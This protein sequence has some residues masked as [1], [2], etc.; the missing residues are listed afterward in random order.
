[1]GYINGSENRVFTDSTFL[2]SHFEQSTLENTNITMYQQ[3]SNSDA[4]NRNVR[5]E[6]IPIPNCWS[7]PETMPNIPTEI[8]PP[9]VLNIAPASY[10]A[11]TAPTVN[12][13]LS[14]QGINIGIT[15]ELDAKLEDEADELL[16]MSDL[17]AE[18]LEAGGVQTHQ[19]MCTQFMNDGLCRFGNQCTFRHIT[20]SAKV[21]NQYLT[22]DNISIRNEFSTNVS[23]P[24]INSNSKRLT[25]NF[26]NTKEGCQMGKYCAYK[27]LQ[28][29]FSSM[30][31]NI[32]HTHHSLRIHEQQTSNINHPRSSSDNF[33]KQLIS[34]LNVLQKR[35]EIQTKHDCILFFLP[36]DIIFYGQQKYNINTL[37]RIA[38]FNKP[39]NIYST[40]NGN[41]DNFYLCVQC[42]Y[43][44]NIYFITLGSSNQQIENPSLQLFFRTSL[45][46]RW[47]EKYCIILWIKWDELPV[48]DSLVTFDSL[49]Y[50]PLIVYNRKLGV[51]S[52][53]K[54]R[55]V[56]STS[57]DIE[58]NVW[59]FVCVLGEEN[60]SS[61][62]VGTAFNDSHKSS[63]SFTTPKYVGS[64]E[65]SICGQDTIRI[66]DCG[67]GPG[68]MACLK[69]YNYHLT[70]E[71]MTHMYWQ[72]KCEMADQWTIANIQQIKYLLFSEYFPLPSVINLIV[73]YVCR[74]EY[75]AIDLDFI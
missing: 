70:V 23:T 61:F 48:F 27:H 52:K 14:T 40:F 64:V 41:E 31:I 18:E 63:N 74:S 5:D 34:K 26:F 56:L 65:N 25:C 68:K 75:Y 32:H 6:I 15:A 39:Y 59:S 8:T 33:N 72:T 58:Y 37:L 62:F 29:T 7:S 69:V 46:F 2:T 20:P 60:R 49:E 13:Y 54:S 42:E 3:Y 19:L 73:Q 53:E 71:A 12:T 66:G 38:P 11:F 51:R 4:D 35:N 45:N 24:D 1:M 36:S 50:S 43:T 67:R 44:T 47:P 30:D 21:Y 9:P 22:T 57:Y 28:P 16:L 10:T 17:A 55:T